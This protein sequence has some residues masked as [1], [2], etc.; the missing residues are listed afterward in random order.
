MSWGDDSNGWISEALT[1][2]EPRSAQIVSEILRLSDHQETRIFTVIPP[3]SS[4]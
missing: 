3:V 2:G 1:P 4:L